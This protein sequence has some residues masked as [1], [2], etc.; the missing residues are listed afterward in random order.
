MSWRG[1]ERFLPV[2][3]APMAADM[4]AA[5]ASKPRASMVSLSNT[6]PTVIAD[7]SPLPP[8]K[9]RLPGQPRPSHAVLRLQNCA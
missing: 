2:N 6:A 5:A 7:E 1:Q 9:P 8:G 4:T 3:V